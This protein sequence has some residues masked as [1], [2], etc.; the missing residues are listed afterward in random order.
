MSDL[1]KC[2]QAP[3]PNLDAIPAELIARGQWVCW[4]YTLDPTLS[5]DGKQLAYL[6]LSQDGYT[7]ALNIAA[8]DGSG[9]HA[10][11]GGQDFQGFY[12]PRFSPDGKQIIVAAIGGPE[13]DNQGK[14]ITASAPSILDRLLSLLEPSTAAAHGLPWDLWVVNTDGTGRRR[15][16]NFYEDLPMVAFSPDGT[17]VAVM[18]YGGIYLMNL[19]GSRLRRIDPLG[20]HGG[21][22]WIQGT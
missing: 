8:P 5:R 2:T 17:Q 14:P 9:S 4:C 7:M 19:D 1:Q 21:L 18:G 22:D 10:I 20:D 11:I 3:A 16:T 6:Q 13:T 12:A 15:L